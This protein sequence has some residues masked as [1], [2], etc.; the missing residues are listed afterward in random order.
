MRLR[1]CMTVAL[2]AVVLAGQAGA[3]SRAETKFESRLIEAARQLALADPRVQALDEARQRKLASFVLGNLVFLLSHELGHALISELKLPVLGREEDAADMFATL[4]MLFVGTDLS[5]QVLLDTAGSLR[6]MAEQDKVS[7]RQP[8]YWGE[9]GLDL[10]RAYQIVCLMVGSRLRTFRAVATTAKM[11]EERQDSCKQDFERAA[12]S[13]SALLKDHGR[14]GSKPKSSLL[15]R[16]LG[17]RRAIAGGER[18]QVRVEY[19]PADTLAAYRSAL[20]AAGLLEMV[21]GFADNN[22]TFPRP[23]ALKAMAC[24]EPNAYWDDRGRQLVLCYELVAQYVGLG[25]QAPER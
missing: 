25:L 19:G 14:S 21:G 13:W 16:L 1:H 5:R 11:P 6:L 7:G 18:T 20:M 8:A 2:L 9:H 22:F 15:A 17:W 3:P 10:Q 4:A 12:K 24:K 23:I